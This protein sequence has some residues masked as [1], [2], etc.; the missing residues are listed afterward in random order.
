MIIMNICVIRAPKTANQ[1]IRGEEEPPACALILRRPICRLY[2]GL[3]SKEEILGNAFLVNI[4]DWRVR[5]EPYGN[6]SRL[7]LVF[8][9]SKLHIMLRNEDCM[10][11]LYLH[12]SC[13]P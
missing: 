6:D 12:G 11:K 1:A 10:N 4:E 2:F 3:L 8:D 9:S 13:W 7:V 5:N